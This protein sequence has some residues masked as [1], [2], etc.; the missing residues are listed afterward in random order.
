MH[1]P[2]PLRSYKHLITK[3]RRL[4]LDGKSLTLLKTQVKKQYLPC[5]GRHRRANSSTTAKAHAVFDGI[6]IERD[7]QKLTKIWDFLYKSK[8][9]PWVT[10]FLNTPYTEFREAWPQ[11][12]LIDEVSPKLNKC[13]A[14][15]KAIEQEKEKPFS[16]T[17]FM[18]FSD[19]T[20]T[21]EM[22]PRSDPPSTMEIVMKK[23]NNFYAFMKMHESKLTHLKL[24]NLTLV[25]PTN[26]FAEPLRVSRREELL[27]KKV[28]YVKEI[29]KSYRPIGQAD[30]NHLIYVA[31]LVNQDDDSVRINR[32]FFKYME[33]KHRQ[34]LKHTS[35][36]ILNNLMSKKLVPNRNNIQKIARAYVQKQFY[37][38][39]E[40]YNMSWMQNFYEGPIHDE[41]GNAAVYEASD[42]SL[43]TR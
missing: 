35:P 34:D 36:A 40:K 7:L 22:L 10:A 6:L 33:R 3:I 11:V 18:G 38:D 15:H 20:T 24:P 27:R 13:N 12:H 28:T 21:F 43:S 30:L 5:G 26:K 2:H 17:T 41:E 31:T 37:V 42:S 8:N 4:P 29:C 23:I 39:Q 32:G 19:Q 1:Q 25:L 16:L 14:Y 9:E